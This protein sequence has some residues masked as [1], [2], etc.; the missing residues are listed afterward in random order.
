MPHPNGPYLCQTMM[1]KHRGMKSRNIYII[2]KEHEDVK[3]NIMK[4]KEAQ[5]SGICAKNMITTSKQ[6]YELVYKLDEMIR[7]I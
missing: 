5:K 2:S 4:I 3:I 1:Q 7:L 6:N